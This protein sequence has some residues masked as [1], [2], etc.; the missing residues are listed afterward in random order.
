MRGAQRLGRN[1][2]PEIVVWGESTWTGSEAGVTG[3][4]LTVSD[5]CRKQTFETV[6]RGDVDEAFIELEAVAVAAMS[7]A[8]FG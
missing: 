3:L 2:T 6:T 5:G 7:N 8:S 1:L 4:S